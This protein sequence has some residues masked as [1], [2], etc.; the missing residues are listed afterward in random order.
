MVAMKNTILITTW[1]G[2][3]LVRDGKIIDERLF[4]KEPESIALRRILI[5]EGKILK[6]EKELAS[7]AGE[8][9]VVSSER[10]SP[11]GDVISTDIEHPSP[12]DKSYSMNILQEAL[13]IEGREGIRKS[14]D[15]DKHLAKAVESIKDLN[16]TINILTERLR[17]W[18]SLHYP[19]LFD[20]RKDIL[21]LIEEYGDRESIENATGNK[22]DSVGSPIGDREKDLLISLASR[23]IELRYYRDDLKN[24][25]EETMEEIAP[26]ITTLTGPRLGGELIAHAGSLK[27]LAMMPAS[28]IQV[29]GA[30][31]SLF[32]HL[33]KGTPPPKHGYILQHPKVHRSAPEV[34]G[35]VARALANKIAIA[36]RVDY[37]GKE[38]KGKDL[39]AEL[40]QRIEHITGN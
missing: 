10:L 32:R 3:F 26:T 22:V 23:I 25:V 40:D 28:T 14:V 9:L 27:K 6:E 2:S 1:F 7:E 8:K 21:E 34:R 33:E 29:L 18:Y 16:E 15:I 12:E 31:K 35:K 19:E 38:N 17:D 37:F 13:R 5:K 11:L 36:S 20:D 4:P 24:Y 39:K 30:E